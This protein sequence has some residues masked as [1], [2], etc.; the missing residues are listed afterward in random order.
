MNPKDRLI[1]ALDVDN[2]DRAQR[3]VDQLHED[4]G[5]FKIGKELFTAEGPQIVR[6][7]VASGAK[8]FLDLKFHDIP[9]TVAKAVG[10]ASQLGASFLTLHLSGGRPMLEAAASALPAEG[11]QL[12]G[13]TVL[14]SHTDATLKETG[15]LG[16]VAETV[17]RLAVL[18]R[19]SGIDGVVCSPHE[20][21]LIREAIGD[22][23]LIVTPGIRP[24]G[25]AKS[26]QARVTTP[27]EALRLGCE[28]IVVGRPITEAASPGDAAR[29]IVEE[30]SQV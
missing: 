6:T 14:T 22:D 4:I 21:T 25:S 17:R 12:L 26:D 16:S 23:I 3:L 15:A 30:L 5:M 29:A 8:V 20:I 24:K 2:Q 9:S 18:A 10:A 1:V 27:R 11:T 28:Y 19:E 13:V 7:I